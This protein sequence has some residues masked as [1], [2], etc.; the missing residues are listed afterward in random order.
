[1]LTVRGSKSAI[2]AFLKKQETTEAPPSFPR[3]DGDTGATIAWIQLSS[4]KYKVISSALSAVSGSITSNGISCSIVYDFWWSA[5]IPSTHWLRHTAEVYRKTDLEFTLVSEVENGNG[6]DD[7]TVYVYQ[8]GK[9]IGDDKMSMVEV[10]ED[11]SSDIEAVI[12]I[13]FIKIIIKDE[14]D[15]PDMSSYYNHN[16]NCKCKIVP[17]EFTDN[18]VDELLSFV[19]VL[20]TC[21]NFDD[22]EE[23]E[24]EEK[25]DNR[26]IKK[27]HTNK[28][29]FE[30]PEFLYE[31]FGLQWRN[32]NAIIGEK[33]QFAYLKAR[34]SK[35]LG[36][37]RALKSKLNEIFIESE[38]LLDDGSHYNFY[39]DIFENTM[40][41]ITG[42]EIPTMDDCRFYGSAVGCM[43]GVHC[44]SAHTNKYAVAECH[45]YSKSRCRNGD[46]CRFRH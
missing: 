44:D 7:C 13:E 12:R 16:I 15:R 2:A 19:P 28:S 43:Y 31:S 45:F 30:I 11:Y 17:I 25:T 38:F 24:E 1:V 42:E 14:R 20:A 21:T 34:N 3:T 40:E 39:S 33:E 18:L 10:F 23:E 32:M 27:R 29:F 41:Q 46:Q 8:S 26:S 9:C 6:C 35:F 37:F 22:E 36:L 5:W 4:I